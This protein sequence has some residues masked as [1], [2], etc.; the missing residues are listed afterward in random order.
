MAESEEQGGLPYIMVKKWKTSKGSLFGP[1]PC[2]EMH[3]S[4]DRA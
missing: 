4:L 1:V 2:P 3:G